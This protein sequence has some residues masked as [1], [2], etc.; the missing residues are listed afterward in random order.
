MALVTAVLAVLTSTCV[1]RGASWPAR[2]DAGFFGVIVSPTDPPL[3]LSHHRG[4]WSSSPDEGRTW[5]PVAPYADGDPIVDLRF[6]PVAPFE[7]FGRSNRGVRVMSLDGGRSWTETSRRAGTSERVVLSVEGT[8]VW[9]TDD[10]G[11]TWRTEPLA[12]PARLV[13]A[14]HVDELTPGRIF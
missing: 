1:L 4:G 5:T 14:L 13:T 10:H 9:R 3:V 2:V 12:L 6:Q 11:Q 8:E 7:M